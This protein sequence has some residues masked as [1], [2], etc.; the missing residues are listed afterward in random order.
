MGKLLEWIRD[1]KGKFIA[2]LIACFYLI[3]AV[4]FGKEY[5]WLKVCMFLPLPLGCIFFSDAMGGYTGILT[6]API[7]KTTPGSFVAF[8]GWLLLLLPLI[9]FLIISCSK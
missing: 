9:S 7:T 1:N 4:L 5:D 6:R 3:M 8:V 2:L